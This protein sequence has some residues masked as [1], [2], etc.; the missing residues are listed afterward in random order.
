MQSIRSESIVIFASKMLFH[1]FPVIH[2][3]IIKKVQ[4]VY[5]YAVYQY[6]DI[7][8]FYHFI[9]F[10]SY[11]PRVYEIC[12]RKAESIVY[13]YFSADILIASNISI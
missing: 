7:L 11:P 13:F 8:S 2:L 10:L 1:D 5:Q 6:A 4:A 12:E 9:T 3:H